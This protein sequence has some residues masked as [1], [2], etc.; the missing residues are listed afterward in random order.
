MPPPRRFHAPPHLPHPHI[1]GGDCMLQ[2]QPA[3]QRQAIAAGCMLH[4]LAVPALR[5]AACAA[6]WRSQV[7]QQWPSAGRGA[8]RQMRGM[9]AVHMARCARARARIRSAVSKEGKAGGA[10]TWRAG[11]SLPVCTLEVGVG[12]PRP[13]AA[14][15]HVWELRRRP[16][17]SGVDAVAAMA[18]GTGPA[19]GDE[20]ICTGQGGQEG[21]RVCWANRRRLA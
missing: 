19:Q 4:P 14:H 16:I 3:Q 9:G 1:C 2:P 6:T 10:A 18:H 20:G 15:S 7:T 8:T 5:G 17:N 11:P 13:C 12:G 21:W